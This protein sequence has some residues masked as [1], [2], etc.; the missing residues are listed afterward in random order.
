MNNQGVK[1][2]IE[3]EEQQEIVKATMTLKSL[4]EGSKE[5]TQEGFELK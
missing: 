4:F 3:E 2:K 1:V 5:I